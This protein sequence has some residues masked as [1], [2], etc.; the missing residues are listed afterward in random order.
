MPFGSGC[1]TRHAR[2][3]TSNPPVRPFI[4][5]F[6]GTFRA[7]CLNHS[8]FTDGHKAQIVTEQWRQEY[9]HRRPHSSLGYLAPAAFTEQIRLSLSVV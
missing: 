7:Q 1:R 6:N 2:Q 9:N 3:C 8:L 5:S 4:E